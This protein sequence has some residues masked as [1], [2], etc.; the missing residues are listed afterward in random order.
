MNFR[1]E[2]F[3][4]VQNEIQLINYIRIASHNPK[5][6]FAL[7]TKNYE[8]AYDVLSLYDKYP[9]NMN[10]VISSLMINKPMNLTKLW[11]THKF[12]KHQLKNFTVYDYDYLKEHPEI[13]INCGSKDCY[14]CHLCYSDR[15]V[16]EVNEI[17]KSDKDR[18]GF[19]EIYR[20]D[21]KRKEFIESTF[22]KLE[23]LI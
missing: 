16:E 6:K 23:E 18:V 13:K 11:S 3:G 21:V 2:A 19:M 1:F 5:T 22:N 10:L 8:V 12:E 17:L 7:F 14:G 4:D 20:D 15:D 9:S